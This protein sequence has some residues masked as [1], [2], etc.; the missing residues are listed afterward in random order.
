[1]WS[2]TLGAALANV[3]CSVS[4][5]L[6]NKA[7]F[8]AGFNFPMSLTFL[9]F[10][11]TVAF[12]R[13]L[14]AC[15]AFEPRSLPHAE[16]FKV[17]GFGVGSIGFMNISLHLNSVGFYQITKLAIVPCTLLAQALLHDVHA[18][19]RVKLSLLLLLLGLA[20][21]TVSDVQLN[22]PGLVLGLLAV[23][24][25]TIFQIWQGSKQK[26]LELSATQ[27]Q[28]AVA[29]WQVP[30]ALAAAIALENLCAG[31]PPALRSE[32]PGECRTAVGFA[33]QAANGGGGD[34]G[35]GARTLALVV[36]TCFV[37][38]GTNVSS[39]CLIGRTSAITFQVVGH[40]K[41]CLVLAGGFLLW[42]PAD[43]S[44][45]PTQLVGVSVAVLGC[46]LYGH[47]KLSEATGRRDLCDRLCPAP[48]LW[49]AT[50]PP[51]RYEPLPASG[52]LI[53]AAD[54]SA[55]D[56]KVALRRPG[57]GGGAADEAADG[58]G[59]EARSDEERRR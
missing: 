14:A 34:G 40:A 22:A 7:V 23:A 27:L 2:L 49:V 24:T 31:L 50:D 30:Q 19:R 36:L 4:L 59:A 28:A 29:T 41:T 6:V 9:H 35:G 33:Q 47:L 20:V 1:M 12:Y 56:A 57:P 26:E 5:V 10:A 54:L 52:E 38:L 15:G 42:P 45:L 44:H 25:T 55:S 18:S 11:F 16:A 53:P 17:A 21:A 13:L 51:P 43:T 37:A 46:V 8:S 39:F 48:L 32:E 3:G 58:G